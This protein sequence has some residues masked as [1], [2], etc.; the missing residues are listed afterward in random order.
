[1]YEY[2]VESL[3]TVLVKIWSLRMTIHYVIEQN[4]TRSH[5]EQ[6]YIE[7][8]FKIYHD[9]KRDA[10]LR[11]FTYRLIDISTLHI[12]ITIYNVVDRC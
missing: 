2:P 11:T 6:T 5:F 12:T 1:M 10:E 8:V 9:R 4:D 7:F 3:K